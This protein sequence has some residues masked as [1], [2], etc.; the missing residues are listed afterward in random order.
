[1]AD[2]GRASCQ[3]VN[4]EIACVDDLCRGGNETLCGLVY[5]YDYGVGEFE[6]DDLDGFWDDG[7]G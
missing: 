7:D 2:Q 4:D 1:M 3:V 5:G 6:D